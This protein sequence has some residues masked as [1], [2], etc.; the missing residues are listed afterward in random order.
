MGRQQ[1]D[2]DCPW[3]RGHGEIDVSTT[4]RTNYIPCRCTNEKPKDELP[5]GLKSIV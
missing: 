4:M 2:L 1:P 3:C 5:D